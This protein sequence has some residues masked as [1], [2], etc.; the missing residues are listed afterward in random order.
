MATK[1]STVMGVIDI[2]IPDSHKY[3]LSIVYMDMNSTSDNVFFVSKEGMEHTIKGFN[4]LSDNAFKILCVP[5]YG[6]TEYLWYCPQ[7]M[8]NNFFYNISEVLERTLENS[9]E[10]LKKDKPKG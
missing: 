9:D 6:D 5:Q 7:K 4:L 10:L 3:L 2:P 8:F 1:S